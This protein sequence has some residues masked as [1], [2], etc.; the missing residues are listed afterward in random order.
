MSW[1]SLY[2]PPNSRILEQE[3]AGK[4]EC[5]QA[6]GDSNVDQEGLDSSALLALASA[7]SGVEIGLNGHCSWVCNPLEHTNML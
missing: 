7:C 2:S 3:E 5:K 1:Y 4:F 6:D